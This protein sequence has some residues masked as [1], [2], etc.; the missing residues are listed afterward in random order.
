MEELGRV[1][2][3]GGKGLGVVRKVGENLAKNATQGAEFEVVDA[4][5][6]VRFAE[7]ASRFGKTYV[8]GTDVVR[9]SSGNLYLIENNR[10]PSF[11]AF[12]DATGIAVE[13]YIVDFL[14]TKSV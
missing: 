3:I 2:V 12:R 14:L 5:E 1:I 7:S 4:E 13:K 11:T 6:V 10:A 9:T 8:Y